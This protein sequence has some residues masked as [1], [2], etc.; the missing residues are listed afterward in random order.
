M[1]TFA[2][3][4]KTHGSVHPGSPSYSSDIHPTGLLTSDVLHLMFIF[5]EKILMNL[6]RDTERTKDNGKHKL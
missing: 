3:R 6:S 5:T 1:L 2:A 4:L